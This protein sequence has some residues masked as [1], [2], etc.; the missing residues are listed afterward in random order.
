MMRGQE[1][2]QQIMA[3]NGV[4]P[5]LPPPNKKDTPKTWAASFL[6]LFN[7]QVLELFIPSASAHSWSILIPLQMEA[8]KL[9]N[10]NLIQKRIFQHN[11]QQMKTHKW[12][13]KWN[14]KKIY[15]NNIYLNTQIQWLIYS[16]LWESYKPLHLFGSTKRSFNVYL[17]RVLLVLHF[18]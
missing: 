6:K 16:V 17:K 3:C 15:R 4:L 12:K 13:N 18:L 2:D 5:P 10:T 8:K 1:V 11:Y 9:E 14:Q 7:P